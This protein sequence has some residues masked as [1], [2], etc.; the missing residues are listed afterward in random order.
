MLKKILL[1]QE[2]I[3]VHDTLSYLAGPIK[4]ESQIILTNHRILVLPHKKWTQS[5]GYKRQNIIWDNV[6]EVTLGKL[7]RN[8]QIDTSVRTLSLWGAGARRM[9]EWIEQWRTSGLSLKTNWAL[10]ERSQIVLSAEVMISVG[11]GLAVTGE[12]LSV[13]Y[14]QYRGVYMVGIKEPKLLH[15]VTEIQVHCWKANIRITRQPST[16]TP[17]PD[18]RFQSTR[19]LCRLFMGNPMGK[20]Q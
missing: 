3:L 12:L 13:S 17:P 11:A 20:H 2:R 9:F 8:I 7:G 18:G 1:D 6:N 5:L 10:L 16:V 15:C 19:Y 14:R 4:I